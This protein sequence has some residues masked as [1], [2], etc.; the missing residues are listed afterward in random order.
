VYFLRSELGNDTF[1]MFWC[2]NKD[3]IYCVCPGSELGTDICVSP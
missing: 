1:Y 3:R 2:K